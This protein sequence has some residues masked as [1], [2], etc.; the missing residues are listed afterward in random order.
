MHQI[1]PCPSC[2]QQLVLTAADLD[3]NP[4]LECPSCGESTNLQTLID[5]LPKWKVYGSSADTEAE[6]ED[7]SGSEPQS[8]SQYTSFDSNDTQGIEEVHAPAEEG[9]QEDP[10]YASDD[11]DP[12]DLAAG[13]DEEEETEATKTEWTDFQPISRDQ[14]QRSRKRARS[15]LWSILQ[16]VLGGA[17]SVPIALLLLWYVFGKDVAD[18]GPTIAQYAPWIVPKQFRGTPLA[19]LDNAPYNQGRIVPG[20][21]QS[22]PPI[23]KDGNGFRNFD[24][25]LSTK[26][27]APDALPTE[28]SE[29]TQEASTPSDEPVAAG[30]PSQLAGE[31]P[32]SLDE[33]PPAQEVLTETSEEDSTSPV[34][35]ESPIQKNVF[36]LISDCEAQLGRWQSAVA[37]DSA[38]LRSLAPEV[39]GGLTELAAALSEEPSPNPRERAIQKALEPIAQQLSDES[40]HVLLRQ[41]SSFWIKQNLSEERLPL[42]LIARV[43]QADKVDDLWEISTNNEQIQ[44]VVLPKG[45][46]APE[47]G[48][49]VVLLGVVRKVK[50]IEGLRFDAPTQRT[51]EA[52]FVVV[53]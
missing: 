7:Y 21:P 23:K 42:A 25:I 50:S 52:Q 30:E 20:Q 43:E 27:Q 47:T 32:L 13:A 6:L 36:T 10:S 17:A 1:L 15:P 35:D 4:E 39:Y 11:S 24:E 45:S 14:H 46:A 29:L 28:S 3:S 41:G 8:E 2:H 34:T 26:N 18:A 53:P 49:E 44:T 51:F 31:G 33:P 37:N 12:T 22:P 9:Q 38:G 16:V 40:V 48:Q 19:N 5:Q